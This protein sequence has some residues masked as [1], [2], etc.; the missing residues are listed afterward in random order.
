M[1]YLQRLSAEKEARE[2]FDQDSQ[3]LKELIFIT[4]EYHSLY[5]GHFLEKMSEFLLQYKKSVIDKI[6]IIKQV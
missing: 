1:N 5:D 2:K 4:N 6:P 3:R